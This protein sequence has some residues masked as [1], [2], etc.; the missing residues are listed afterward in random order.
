MLLMRHHQKAN[1]KI[2]ELHHLSFA[3]SAPAHELALASK[4]IRD[5]EDNVPVIVTV[6]LYL[7]KV[8][9]RKCQMLHVYYI[10]CINS[11]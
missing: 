8:A 7:D 4:T 5:F 3:T 1:L 10:S 11:I 6:E 2:T 9:R